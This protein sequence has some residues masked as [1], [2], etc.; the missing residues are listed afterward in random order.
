[1]QYPFLHRSRC[2]CTIGERKAK[3]KN[4]AGRFSPQPSVL[5]W[6]GRKIKWLSLSPTWKRRHSPELQNRSSAPSSGRGECEKETWPMQF[7]NC[8]S[9]QFVIQV[10]PT[11]NRNHYL[12]H[13][14][15]PI[16]IGLYRSRFVRNCF[17]WSFEPAIFRN[18]QIIL[19]HK[20]MNPLLINR[21][22]FMISEICP[23]TTITLIWMFR[24][25]L[26]DLLQ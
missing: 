4:N 16:S 7:R 1:M 14:D 6:P 8:F 18:Q 25:Q 24:L 10:D 12:G 23:D 26:L 2:N 11:E 9:R 20:A 3:T 22:L 17:A 21:K 13:I 15:A 5:E 19:P